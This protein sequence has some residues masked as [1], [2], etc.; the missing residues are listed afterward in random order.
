MTC[1]LG[2]KL[3]EIGRRAPEFLAAFEVLADA[4]LKRLDREQVPDPDAHVWKC[5]QPDV[6]NPTPKR[7]AR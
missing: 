1:T 3:A 7:R 4:E 5:D 2:D 6:I